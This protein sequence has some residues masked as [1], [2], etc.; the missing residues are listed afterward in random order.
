MAQ[1]QG[2]IWEDPK[3]YRYQDGYLFLGRDTKN[4][5]DV[6]IPARRHAITFG[7]SGAGKGVTVLTPNLL[8]N[9]DKNTL[10]IDPKGELAKRTAEAREQMGQAVHVVDPFNRSRVDARFLASYN[11]LD[12]L[13]VNSITISDDITFIADGIVY[14]HN[15]EHGRWDNN[16]QTIIS[17]LIAFVKL[18][19][20][21]DKKN[22]ME[23]RN[24]LRTGDM[25]KTAESMS[26]HSECGGLMQA[27]AATIRSEAGEQFLETARDNTLWLDNPAIQTVLTTSTFSL[28]DLKNKKT[29]VFLVLPPEYLKAHGRFLRLFVR[30][31]LSQMQRLTPDG[32]EKGETCLFLLDEFYS[33]GRID[34]LVVSVG[35]MRSMGLI[36][37]PF[38]QDLSQLV[39][40]YRQDSETFFGNSDLHQ[41]FGI[42]DPFTLNAISARFGAFSVDEIDAPPES[43][44]MGTGQTGLNVGG[45]VSNLGGFSQNTGTRAAFGV[46][47][48]LLSMGGGAVSAAA[49]SANMAKQAEYQQAMANYQHQA[50]IV[51]KSRMPPE[52]VARLI[53]N[54]DDIVASASINFVFGNRV[55]LAK[56]APYFLQHTHVEAQNK[57]QYLYRFLLSVIVAIIVSTTL[58]HLLYLLLDVI[59]ESD[60]REHQ[61]VDVVLNV[62]FGGILYFENFNGHYVAGVLVGLLLWRKSARWFPNA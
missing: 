24:I 48:S 29:S 44:V 16:A 30:C 17:G 34:E 40:L 10:T 23:V 41:F 58:L 36:L 25:K 43:P 59:W 54:K 61:I 8:R 53:E 60:T 12:D 55:L 42:T 46:V 45:H 13:N 26:E 18:F 21:L 62:V 9:A 22:L 51:G 35:Q 57:K 38:L 5:F 27:A 37:W 28:S 19:A 6:G 4:K 47:G 49:Q 11:P 3:Q 31:S 20:P 33:L 14:R 15:P 52:D 2:G 56:P 1:N 32:Q 7:G 50:Q 39:S